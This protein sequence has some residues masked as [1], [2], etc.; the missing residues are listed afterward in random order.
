MPEQPEISVVSNSE[1]EGLAQAKE[2]TCIF[3]TNHIVFLS[4]V[5][6]LCIHPDF[7]PA[8][9]AQDPSSDHRGPTAP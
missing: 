4:E 6:A 1:E 3:P 8:A 7:V 2:K 5:A 9:P